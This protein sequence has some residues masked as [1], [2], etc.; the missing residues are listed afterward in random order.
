[1]TSLIVIASTAVF[2]MRALAP[3]GAVVVRHSVCDRA[4]EHRG[5]HGRVGVPEHGLERPLQ[6]G[7]LRA[8]PGPALYRLPALVRGAPARP[9]PRAWQLWCAAP[10][11]GHPRAPGS[12]RVLL[13]A[14]SPSLV[15]T[16]FHPESHTSL[17]APLCGRQPILMTLTDSH[18]VR[19]AKPAPCQHSPGLGRGEQSVSHSAAERSCCARQVLP[20]CAAARVAGLQA[21][22]RTAPRRGRSGGR[23]CS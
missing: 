21:D 23:P 5:G 1:V 16:C 14:R 3:A 7:R 18:R 8:A 15:R 22:G 20:G 13:W 2:D 19:L 10:L 17:H 6:P 12:T 4:V 9:P 11:R